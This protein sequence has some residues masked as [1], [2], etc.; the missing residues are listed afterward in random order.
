M[1]NAERICLLLVT[2]L[3][4]GC[5]KYF[6]YGSPGQAALTDQSLVIDNSYKLFVRETYKSGATNE[7]V[8]R[9]NFSGNSRDKKDL[10][11]VEYLI[12]SDIQ[13]KVLYFSTI[14]DKRQKYYAKHYLG[15]NMINCYD[16][17]VL[18]TGILDKN[19]ASEIGYVSKD[20][21]STD[22]WV[23]E[24]N[25]DKTIIY[26]NSIVERQNGEFTDYLLVKEALSDPVSFVKS[27]QLE[28]VY[29]N[30]FTENPDTAHLLGNRIYF[31]KNK[32]KYELYFRFDKALKKNYTD[33]YFKDK[34]ILY[35]PEPLF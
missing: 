28:L 23:M 32:N 1:K 17:R 10:I 33:I 29:L 5:A 34:R 7:K 16:L 25:N 31:K 9:T 35:N 2:V 3:M 4:T 14:P 20:G 11:E 21:K 18:Y 8:M 22:T 24:Y 26:L 27:A 12:I 30:P 13:K 19:R 15:P 6:S